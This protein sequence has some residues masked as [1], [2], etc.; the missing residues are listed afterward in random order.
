MARID[1]QTASLLSLCQRAGNLVSGEESTELALKSKKAELVIIAED[2]ADNTKNK[3]LNK[4][5]FYNVN[6]V[7]YGRKEELSKC[8]GKFNR[9]VFAVVENCGFA[10]RRYQLI[11]DSLP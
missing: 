6:V 2:A 7:V 11:Q 5:E 10:D 3:F 9:T 4:A 8:I 1:R